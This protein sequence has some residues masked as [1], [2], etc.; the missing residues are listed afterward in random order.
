[1]MKGDSMILSVSELNLLIAE[2]IRKEPRTRSVT[3][4]GEISGFKHHVPSGHWYFS[5]KDA[6]A[7][8][9]CVMFRQNTARSQVLPRDGMA[10]QIT[11]YVDVYP[12]NGSLQLYVTSLRT[13][14]IGDLFIQLE[15]LKQR[16]DAEGLF[17]PRRKRPLP[18]LPNKVAVVTSRSGAALHDIL[19]VSGQRCPMIPIVLVPTTVQGAG[20]GVEIAAAVRKAGQIPGVDVILLGRGGGSVEDLWCFNDETLVRAIAASRVPVITGIG[21]E[22]DTTL[23]DYAADVRASTPSNAAEIAFPDRRE[24]LSR[25]NLLRAGLGRAAENR[26]RAVQLQLAGK[27]ERLTANKPEVRLRELL[28]RCHALRE[29][30][31]H[32][33]D[34]RLTRQRLALEKIMGGLQKGMDRRQDAAAARMA[35]YKARLEAISPLRVL[36]RGY[37]MVCAEDG[38][39][40]TSAQEAA[41]NRK[42]LLRY[43]DGN[44]R[45]TRGD[46]A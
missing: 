9:S 32:T 19:N 23:S 18:M 8:I 3:V 43:A 40:I 14:G 11:G 26:V 27:K 42:M 16:L 35:E 36:D 4:Q 44:V 22:V 39:L 2:A 10:V 1:M 38:H 34:H 41:R 24:L 21:H 45:V 17:D 15:A 33:A 20:A 7:A 29:N 31:L 13:G 25:L 37:A 6:N 5:L 46:E 28:A 12:K 30:L